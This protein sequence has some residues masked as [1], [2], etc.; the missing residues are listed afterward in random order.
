MA[1]IASAACYPG[2]GNL[3]VRWNSTQFRDIAPE[4]IRALRGM[5]ASSL[6]AET[7]NVKNIL[8]NALADPVYI[9]LV[10][11]SEIG[12]IGDSFVL[13]NATGETVALGDAPGIEPSADRLSLL[14]DERLL[15]DQV[16]LGA[17]Y[18]DVAER[19][20]KLQPLSILTEDKVIRL[21]Y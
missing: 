12:R 9:R 20:L 5:A 17:F 4:D 6:A 21:L 14:P 18:Y 7:K 10:S 16:L 19:R 1:Q 15:K 11:F 2:Q 13:K 8:K 3:R